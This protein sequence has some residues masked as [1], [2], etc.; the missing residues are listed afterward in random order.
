MDIGQPVL[1]TLSSAS[2]EVFISDG[3]IPADLEILEEEK[4]ICVK[5]LGEYLPSQ[6]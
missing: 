2:Q 5:H 6:Y 1:A 3:F 4:L